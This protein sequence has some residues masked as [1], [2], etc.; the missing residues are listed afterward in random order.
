MPFNGWL[1]RV[2]CICGHV[3][4]VDEQPETCP[5]CGTVLEVRRHA[6][7][8]LQ[9]WA[10]VPDSFDLAKRQHNKPEIVGWREA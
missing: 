3:M 5:K 7:G 2:Q 4:L 9:P 6:F 10:T 1:A 8:R